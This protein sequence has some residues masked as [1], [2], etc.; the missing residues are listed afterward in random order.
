[1][2]STVV[3]KPRTR[4][5][6]ERRDDLMDAAARLFLA[7]GLE[8]TT[9]EEI[10]Q[11]AGVAKGSFY[12]HF[13]TKTDVLEALRGRFVQ[14][15]LDAIIVEV[16]KCK[17]EDW[18]GKLTAWS[19]AC[20]MGYLDAIPLHHFVFA[21]APPAPTAGLARNALVDDLTKLLAAGRSENAWPVDDP[22]FTAIFLFNGLHGAV[23][24]PGIGDRPS[25]RRALLRAIDQ[26]FR[27]ALGLPPAG[28]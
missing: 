10:T 11:G 19:G 2:S 26:Q 6:A 8:N 5:A 3:G 9:V 7:Q 15:V 17:P 27:R 20:A 24:Q 4:P 25:D 18:E 13:A 16:A 14:S 1:M 23:N 21:A 22:G 12:L 28:N